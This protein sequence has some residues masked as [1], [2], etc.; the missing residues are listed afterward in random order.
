MNKTCFIDRDGVINEQIFDI[1]RQIYR[2]PWDVS[3]FK[4]KPF[5]IESLKRLNK[6]YFLFLVTNQPDFEKGF[7]SL[8]KL[9]EIKY[10]L[11]NIMILNKI[12]FK[13]HYYCF[14]S[15]E[16]KCVCRKPSP[17]FLFKASKEYH[18]DLQGSWFIGD[19]D[20]DIKCGQNAGVRTILIENGYEND[21]I[22]KSVPDYKAKNIKEAT[23]IILKGEKI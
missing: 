10:H 12:Y 17:H 13:E 22:G 23:D 18:I 6:E 11:I 7:I 8:R 21:Y 4:L 5:V 14:H 20:L 2:P 3:E 16:N 9:I 19:S 1:N 15:S